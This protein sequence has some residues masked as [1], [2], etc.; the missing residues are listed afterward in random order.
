M[1]AV[2]RSPVG[3]LRVTVDAEAVFEWL[4]EFLAPCLEKEGDIAPG[5]VDVRFVI[6]RGAF[7]ALEAGGAEASGDL[8]D[9]FR[10][11]QDLVRL[12]RWR[13]GAADVTVFDEALG[14]FYRR[15]RPGEPVEVVAAGDSARARVAVMRVIREL[16]MSHLAAA[17]W[18]IVHASA[19][20][21]D[22]HAVLVAGPKRAGKTTLLTYAMTTGA[23]QCLAN[24]RVAIALDGTH[25]AWGVP[26]IVSLRV[27]MMRR[28]PALARRLQTGQYDF[29]L[30]RRELGTAR[31]G[32]VDVAPAEAWSVTPMQYCNLVGVSL[33]GCAPAS[34]VVFPR[35]VDDAASI[36][37][38]PMDSVESAERLAD[39]VFRPH[40]G[41]A[42]FAGHGKGV[43]ASEA[44]LLRA[45]QSFIGRIA[46]YACRIGPDARNDG[47]WIKALAR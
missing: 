12:P 16:T 20:V 7:D 29:R 45:S 38:E 22:G 31:A 11:D 1:R 24:D 3:A 25:T 15:C 36:D 21:V 33:A 2:Y 30:S 39:S 46:R 44:D 6:D 32:D 14:A 34:A 26:T 10:L 27:P 19:F 8:V 40:G 13:D 47:A 9:C 28:F 5:A 43:P 17:G 18:M 23:A 41:Q 4:S 35:L 42:L 37:L